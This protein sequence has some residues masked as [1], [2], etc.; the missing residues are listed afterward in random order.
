MMCGA[1]EL[2]ARIAYLLRLNG[3]P[4]AVDGERGFDHGLFI[5]LKLMYPEAD[6]PCW[7]PLT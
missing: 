2:A 7:H 6:I 5:P 4:S 3:V 1:P